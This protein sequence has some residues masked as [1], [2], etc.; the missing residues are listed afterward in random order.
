MSDVSKINGYNIKDQTAREELNNKASTTHG[1]SF[2][3]SGNT[4]QFVVETYT[5]QSKNISGNSTASFEQQISKAGYRP[6]GVVGTYVSSSNVYIRGAYLTDVANGSAT[7]T[8]Y[9]KNTSSSTQSAV[10]ATT[11][12]LWAKL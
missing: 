1:H 12:V 2:A 11:R 7:I 9:V 6:V 8:Y 3:Q 4:T 10:S 5:S